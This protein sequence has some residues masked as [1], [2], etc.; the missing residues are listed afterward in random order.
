MFLISLHLKCPMISQKNENCA[1]KET[2]WLAKLQVLEIIFRE[3]FK[4]CVLLFLYNV[5]YKK[6]M[7]PF[8]NVFSTFRHLKRYV[9]RWFVLIT[10]NSNLFKILQNFARVDV[11]KFSFTI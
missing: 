6:A 11:V 9:L 8:L 2:F 7:K 1:E 5:F 4:H 3:R 10:R